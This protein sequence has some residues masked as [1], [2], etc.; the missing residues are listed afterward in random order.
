MSLTSSYTVR[1]QVA[2]RLRAVAAP[3]FAATWSQ[4]TLIVHV[5]AVPQRRFV[6]ANIREALT[7]VVEGRVRIV[8]HTAASLLAPRSLERLVKRISGDEI[9]YDPTGSIS[10]AKSLVSAARA[11]R[12]AL[13]GKARGIFYAP[14]L[15]TLFVALDARRVGNGEKVKLGELGEIE[16]QI[17]TALKASFADQIADCPAIRVGFGVPAIELVPVDQRSVTGF[18]ARLVQAVRQYW[19]PLAIAAVF[20]LG[21]GTAAAKDPAVSQT[22]LKVTG[23]GGQTESESTWFVNGMLTAPLGHSWGI[24]VEGGAGGIDDDTIYGIGGHIFT[25]DPDSYLL[26]IF[27]A[28]SA[29]DKWDLD[30]TRLGA[31]AEIYLNQVSILAQAGY[32]FSDSTQETAFGDIE[33][34]WYLT[35]NFA[36]SGGASF[37]ENSTIGTAGIEWQ[38]GFSALPGLAFRVDGAWG[39]DEFDSVMGGIT[40]YFGAN[41]HLKDRHR[42]Q[43]P[44]SAL[45]GLFQSVQQEQKR[46][47]A[48]YGGG[49]PQ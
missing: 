39:E 18:G 22:N 23:T 10:R 8:F 16:R 1:E 6:K 40:Y 47:D 46:L 21:A 34:R 41:A 11:T 30:A 19:K 2:D 15:R 42:R 43:D 33:L 24:Q 44:D 35:D 27:A 17:L 31:E 5:S 29:E 26:G 48:L 20:G 14:R 28:Y 9:A 36:L 3:V 13:D 25:R 4:E 12:T 49:G 37:T 32:Q 45:F 7:S 38:P